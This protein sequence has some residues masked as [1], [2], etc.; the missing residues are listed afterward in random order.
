[1]HLDIGLNANQL[2]KSKRTHTNSLRSKLTNT[3]SKVLLV[4]R[5]TIPLDTR[6][7]LT[8]RSSLQ[9]SHTLKRTLLYHFPRMLMYH[10]LSTISF[11][12]ETS[13][14]HYFIF[15][16]LSCLILDYNTWFFIFFFS[17]RFH[18]S[19]GG[20]CEGFKQPSINKTEVK[21]FFQVIKYI[22]IYHFFVLIKFYYIVYFIEGDL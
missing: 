6:M 11:G 3:I 8:P 21:F 1:M 17:C 15:S 13:M 18:L 22:Y 14:V 9:T 19:V 5:N 10:T 12:L 16:L 2:S 4:N 7:A 20:Q